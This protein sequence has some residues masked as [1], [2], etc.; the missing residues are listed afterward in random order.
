M[1]TGFVAGLSAIEHESV[2]ADGLLA[3]PLDGRRRHIHYTHVRTKNPQDVLPDQLTREEFWEHILRCYQEVYP[4]AESETGSILQ[5]GLVCKEKHKD[6]VRDIDRSEH[7]HAATFCCTP[8]FWRRVRKVSQEKL[9][10][11]LERR[12]A[13]GI[14]HN[15]QLPSRAHQEE[16]ALRA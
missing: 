13:R 11:P 1:T 12:G 2:A 3:L 15:V 7:H 10:H 6:A 8:H 16:A 9:Q 14:L 5:F 4:K